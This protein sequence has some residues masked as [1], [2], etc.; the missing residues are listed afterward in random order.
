MFLE[1]RASGGCAI[2]GCFKLRTPVAFCWGIGCFLFLEFK[3]AP[4]SGDLWSFLG[5][6]YDVGL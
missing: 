3:N 1:W 4:L 6:C 5:G 2:L